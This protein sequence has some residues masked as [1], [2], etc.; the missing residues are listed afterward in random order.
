[1]PL[2]VL[3]FIFISSGIKK[4]ISSS[5]FIEADNDSL[6][7]LPMSLNE[8][9]SLAISAINSSETPLYRGVR[10][11]FSTISFIIDFVNIFLYS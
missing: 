8:P 10:P 2:L 1:M 4:I 9:S 5:L 3:F 11:L 7:T 6:I